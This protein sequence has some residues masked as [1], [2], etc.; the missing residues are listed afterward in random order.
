MNRGSADQCEPSTQRTATQGAT[1]R[2]VTF[3]CT[4]ALVTDGLDGQQWEQNFREHMREL[5]EAMGLSQAELARRIRAKGPAFHQQTV[6]RIE[7]GDR[8]VRL[9]E[10]FLVAEELAASLDEMTLQPGW[11]ELTLRRLSEEVEDARA[12]LSEAFGAWA[13]ARL[14][15]AA[16]AD[17]GD[18]PPAVAHQVEAALQ[19]GPGDLLGLLVKAWGSA[20]S[21]S[22]RAGTGSHV[23]HLLAGWDLDGEHPETS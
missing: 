17:E 5:R 2:V 11:E 21:S 12:A 16:V 22:P 23:T 1:R 3:C 8:P 7:S 6:A 10:A 18:L 14:T 15:L 9:N 13:N 4:V 19:E 20:I